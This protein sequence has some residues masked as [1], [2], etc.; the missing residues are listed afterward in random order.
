[1]PSRPVTAPGRSPVDA[2][3]PPGAADVVVVGA[4]LAGLACARELMGSGL[5]VVVLEADDGVGGRVR[6]DDVDGVLVDRG[7]Q[8]LN[9]TYP[10]LPWF[11]DVDAL[12]LQALGAGVVV[13]RGDDPTTRTLLA[14][15]VRRP[16]AL[17]GVLR[18]GLV[19][20]RDLV[21][22]ARL[23]GRALALPVRSLERAPDTGWH[24][25]F[26]AA[27]LDGPL[28]RHVVEPFLTG[29]L[30]DADGSTSRRHVDLLLRSFVK[31]GLGAAPGLPT[32][33]MQAFSDAV[34]APLPAGSVRTRARVESLTA[35]GDG[36][37]VHGVHADGEF[38]VVAGTVVLA[39]EARST[40][41]LLERPAAPDRALTT[42]W[43]LSAEPLPVARRG[44]YLHVDGDRSHLRR[45]GL[46]NTVVVSR[47]APDYLP[48]GLHGRRDLVATTVL[49]TFGDERAAA[50][51]SIR[52]Q[53]ARVL[54]A[55]EQQLGD[56]VAVHEIPHA[57]PRSTPP[58][59]VRR[60]VDLTDG[61]FVVGDHRDTPSI[62]GA[63]VSGRRGA[64]AVLEH[65]GLGPDGVR[66]SP[67]T[68]EDSSAR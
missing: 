21:G 23:A 12:R 64:R 17:P 1:M 35:T 49:G 28:R 15:P 16:D 41:S 67:P 50:L 24:A 63:L 42:V 6:T 38:A 7:F 55:S 58:L 20:V 3:G 13:A 19:T 46:V 10:V 27:G 66:T 61:R 44:H 18:S 4:G 37:T 30:A 40:A 22:L 8:L 56:E 33:G 36:W 51:R 5:D 45:F 31:A 26:D 47:S 52:T 53:A 29:T 39:G 68:R 62:Q 54:G 57:L 14:D 48:P 11:V 25:A 60:P 32:G 9:P 59:D 2:S 43:H 34:A 65:L